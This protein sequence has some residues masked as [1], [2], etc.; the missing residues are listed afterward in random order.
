MIVGLLAVFCAAPFV[1]YFWRQH[2]LNTPS[3]RWVKLAGI[4]GLQYEAA[5]PRMSGM[6][7][8]RRAAVETAPEG[9]TLS[10][11]LSAPTRL[12]VECGPREL[13]ARRAGMVVPDPVAA[14][15][16]AFGERLLA[17]CSDKAAGP[18]VFDAAL[19][20]RLAAL[21]AVDLVGEKAR[22]AWTVP[23]VADIDLLEAELSALCAVADGL[24]QFPLTGGLPRA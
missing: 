9:A 8:G 5:P 10:V 20:K 14:L 18:V 15:D 6:Y 2:E 16:A 7:S 21:P 12:R 17:R 24:E 1:L 22:V 11:W 3:R 19:Q 13:V 4:L 23:A